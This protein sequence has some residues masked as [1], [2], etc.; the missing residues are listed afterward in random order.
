MSNFLITP[1]RNSSRP[2]GA[3]CLAAGRSPSRTFL[4]SG[5]HAWGVR[6]VALVFPSRPPAIGFSWQVDDDVWRKCQR[7]WSQIR[8]PASDFHGFWPF[9]GMIFG[10]F[11]WRVFSSVPM[12]SKDVVAWAAASA[13]LLCVEANA[14]V[15]AFPQLG[16]LNEILKAQVGW[17]AGSLRSSHQWFSAFE[18]ASTW[19]YPSLGWPGSAGWS[20]RLSKFWTSA[21]TNFE[22]ILWSGASLEES[23][24]AWWR[25]LTPSTPLGEPTTWRRSRL[26]G[27][28]I[29]KPLQWPV[30]KMNCQCGSNL[31]E[32]A[33]FLAVVLPAGAMEALGQIQGLALAS[34]APIGVPNPQIM[35]VCQ[36]SKEKCQVKLNH[37]LIAVRFAKFGNVWIQKWM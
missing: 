34:S 15:P 6:C 16:S 13:E 33:V 7:I 2:T 26:C 9:W 10:L 28:T 19:S 25:T 37:Q 27:C 1:F 17:L 24:W 22:R 8:G 23:R 29:S 21:G 32:V 11:F 14:N 20:P 36:C 30:P 12:N 5:Q 35:S 3:D 18:N 31:Q 4:C